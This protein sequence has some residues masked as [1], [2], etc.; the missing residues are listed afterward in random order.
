[1]DQN[2][3]EQISSIIL[4][5]FSAF[6]CFFSYQISIG[7]LRVPGGGFF[8]FYLGAILGLLS[9]ANLAKAIVQGKKSAAKGETSKE[10][11]NWRNVI[12]VLVALFSYP[13]L[14][15]ILG[16]LPVTFI[17]TACFLRFIEP[18]RWPVVLGLGGGI[19]VV[20]YLIFQYWLKV[21]FP[22]GILG[23]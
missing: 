12:I 11:I 1:M 23:I 7:S 19:A 5:L 16:F 15:N 17:F 2:K 4:I 3:K 21:Q 9:I 10:G 6:F 20:S 8:P 13:A 14:L 18:Q 22:T